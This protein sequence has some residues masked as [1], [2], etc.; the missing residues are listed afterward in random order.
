MTYA[1]N[2]HA[3]RLIKVLEQ[4]DTCLLCPVYVPDSDL[5]PSKAECKLCTS[6]I[7]LPYRDIQQNKC[8]CNQLGPKEAAKRSWI[9]LEE[10]GYI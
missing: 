4:E 10:K 8:P 1:E 2:I 3:P 9:A 6:F 5:F 7:G